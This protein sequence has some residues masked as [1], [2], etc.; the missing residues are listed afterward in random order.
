MIL[1][2]NPES[3]CNNLKPS[4]ALVCSIGEIKVEILM[5]SELRNKEFGI[6]EIITRGWKTFKDKFFQINI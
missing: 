4:E 5:I 6:I 3:W 2:K 1:L